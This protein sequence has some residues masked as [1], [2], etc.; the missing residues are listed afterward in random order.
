MK[1][2]NKILI[3]L[4]VISVITSAFVLSSSAEE[5]YTVSGV[6][7][8]NSTLTNTGFNTSEYY[9]QKVNFVAD[10]EEYVALYPYYKYSGQTQMIYKKADGTLKTTHPYTSSNSSSYKTLDFGD[11]PQ[12]VSEKFY[13]WITTNGKE[14][15]TKCDGSTCPA[16]DLNADSICDDCGMTL[17]LR[18][19]GYP[20]LPDVSGDNMHSVV[21]QREDG[22]LYM[23]LTSDTPYTVGGSVGDNFLI[24]VANEQDVSFV[25][26]KCT[27]GK[28]WVNSNSGEAY[29]LS[30]GA[31]SSTLLASTFDWYK[32]GTIFFRYL[33]GRR[34][35]Q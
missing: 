22:Y 17:S 19:T 34:W 28:N 5:N 4:L 16:T 26:Y 9:E 10:G 27:D 6:W 12:T 7:Q 31:P 20:P 21:I 8:L 30:V 13:T 33:Y 11:T 35:K 2:F 29:S 1:N 18:Y 32:D 24:T 15:I 23:V 14:I 3:V 25:A